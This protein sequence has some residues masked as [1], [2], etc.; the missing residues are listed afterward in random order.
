[1]SYMCLIIGYTF[2]G[3]SR[4]ANIIKVIIQAEF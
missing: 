4:A 2:S 1:M 3:Q